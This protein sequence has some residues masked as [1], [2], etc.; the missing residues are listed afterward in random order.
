MRVMRPDGCKFVWSSV[1]L[2]ISFQWIILRFWL[3]FSLRFVFWFFYFQLNLQVANATTNRE[4]AVNSTI[5]SN[6]TFNIYFRWFFLFFWSS[7]CVHI[8][9]DEINKKKVFESQE[10]KAKR[11]KRS[12]KKRNEMARKTSFGPKKALLLLMS[13]VRSPFVDEF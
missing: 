6:F 8:D 4:P 3:R 7:T 13:L 1:N 9:G 12:L 2:V 5:K 10:L 11:H